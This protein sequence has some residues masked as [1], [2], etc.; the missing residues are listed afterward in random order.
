ME[1]GQRYAVTYEGADGALDE[2]KIFSGEQWSATQF[3]TDYNNLMG[4]PEPATLALLAG[5][6]LALAAWRRKRVP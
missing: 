4:I 5:G 3:Q 2:V 1:V 6:A